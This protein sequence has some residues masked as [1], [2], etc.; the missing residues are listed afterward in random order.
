MRAGVVFNLI[1]D[2]WYGRRW[3]ILCCMLIPLLLEVLT[4]WQKGIFDTW[5]QSIGVGG[6]VASSIVSVVLVFIPYAL[7]WITVITRLSGE[8]SSGFYLF[9]RGMP[10]TPEEIITAKFVSSLVISAGAALWFAMLWWGYVQSLSQPADFKIWAAICLIIFFFPLGL[11]LEQALFFRKG[12]ESTGIVYILFVLVLFFGKS[13]FVKQGVEWFITV[14]SD[15]PFITIGVGTIISVLVWLHCWRWAMTS[16]RR[17]LN[18][19]GKTSENRDIRRT[20]E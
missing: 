16:Y 2:D 14:L 8:A 17:Y 18:G 13:D 5:F 20:A 11:A 6:V 12:A 15:F 7:I 4:I 10:I 1:K 19:T 3:M 9:V